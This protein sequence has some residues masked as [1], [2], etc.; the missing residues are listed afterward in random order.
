MSKHKE[1]FL[2]LENDLNRIRKKQI[3]RPQGWNL[4]YFVTASFVMYWF[5]N[6]LATGEVSNGELLGVIQAITY[7]ALTCQWGVYSLANLSVCFEFFRRL[8]AIENMPFNNKGNITDIPKDRTIKF[9]NVSF[10]YQENNCVIENISFEIKDG[11]HIAL[12]GENGAG[13]STIIKLLCRLY[14]PD[15]GRITV[16]GVDINEIDVDVW[17]KNISAIFQDFGHYNL[18]V[19]ENIY[20]GDIENIGDKKALDKTCENA[21]FKLPNGVTYT[22][23]L[24]KEYSGAELSGG[25]WQRLAIARALY[26]SKSRIVILDE[27]TS[28]LDP[29]IEASFFKHFSQ[30]TKNKTSIMVTHRMGSVKNSDKIIVLKKGKIVE[31]GTPDELLELNGEYCELLNIQKEIWS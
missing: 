15:T 25:Q 30:C 13:K 20:L 4:L 17:R 24:G 26:S 3:I 14:Y 5:S 18:T 23:F 27:P 29:R 1:N 12:I 19:E 11:E 16:G 28:A 31:Q 7:F 9:E 22:T 6:Y 2:E 8:F 21:G 10:S